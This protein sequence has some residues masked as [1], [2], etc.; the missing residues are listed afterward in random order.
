[1]FILLPKQL[2]IPDFPIDL[3]K[4]SISL[5]FWLEISNRICGLPYCSHIPKILPTLQLETECDILLLKMI[6][7]FLINK[8]MVSKLLKMVHNTLHDWPS[9]LP[10]STCIPHACKSMNAIRKACMLAFSSYLGS[11]MPP[12]SYICSFTLLAIQL[13]VY[14]CVCVCNC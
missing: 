7:C 11:Q 6:Q 1:M 10:V 4:T 2:S 13:S 3:F 5:P 9:I 14:L 8:K 12:C